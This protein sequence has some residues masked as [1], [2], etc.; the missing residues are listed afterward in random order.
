MLCWQLA[1][2]GWRCEGPDRFVPPFRAGSNRQ[3]QELETLQL[4]ETIERYPI[5]I[6]NFRGSR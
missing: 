4:I 5:L 1:F 6:A 2:E 3:S